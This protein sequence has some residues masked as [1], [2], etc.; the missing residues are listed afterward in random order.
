MMNREM[1]ARIC[2]EVRDRLEHQHIGCFEGMEKPLFLI[3]QQYPGVWLEHVYDS[4]FYALRNPSKVHLAENTLELFIDRQKEDGQ[5]PCFVLNPPKAKAYGNPVGYGQIQ[6]CVSFAKLCLMVCR[7]NGNAAFLQKCYTACLRWV[8]WLEAKRMT[9]QRGLVELFVGFDTGHDNSGRL[10]G[11]SRQGNYAEPGKAAD[12]ALLPP[13]DEAAP[14]LAVDM[15][16]NYYA[17]LRAL[18]EM[19]SMLGLEEERAAWAEKAAQVKKL[20]FALCFDEAD[21]F[22]YDVDKHG[23]HR[24]YLSSTV[25]HLFLE[26]VL[27]REEDAALIEELLKRHIRNPQEF[28][29]PYP[30]PS[31]AINDP[32][33]EGHKDFNCWGYYTQGLIALRT[34]MWMED[35]GLQEEHLHLCRQWVKAWTEHFSELKMGQELDPITGIPTKSSEWYSSTMLFYLYAAER[36]GLA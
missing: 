35:Y 25:F 34:T 26:G 24:K 32:S 18:S 17:N 16:C 4:V 36:L 31:M 5:L 9:S 33:C 10:A 14:I 3:S 23:N 21:C 11:M 19:A 29:T 7:M 20:L 2:E 15:N 8:G 22:F 6:E 1:V 27:D 30:Y 13:D 28:A 12:A